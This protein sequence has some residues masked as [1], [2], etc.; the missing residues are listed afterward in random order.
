M[1][2][3]CTAGL[4]VININFSPMLHVHVHR[5]ADGGLKFENR[6]FYL[7]HPHLTPCSVGSPQNFGMKLAHEKL[8]GWATVW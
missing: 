5:F 3:A 8:E 2:S 1:E 4:L 6:K 7:R